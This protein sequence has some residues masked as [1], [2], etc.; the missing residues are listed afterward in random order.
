M[1]PTPVPTSAGVAVVTGGRSAE[2]DRSLLSGRTV[3][4]SLRRQGYQ[5]E[6]LDLSAPGFNE[7]VAG[8]DVAF[9]AIAGQWAEDGKLQGLLESLDVP[10][11]GS[12]VAASAVAMHKAMAKTVV[13]AAGVPVLPHVELHSGTPGS[14]PLFDGG[15]VAFPV[16]IKPLSEGGSVGMAICHT[17]QEI[18]AAIG[19]GTRGAA[20]LAEPFTPGPAITA[21][22]IERDGRPTALTPLETIPT[23]GA[24]YDYT[25]KRN[26]DRHVY[27]CP[28]AL[29]QTTVDAVRDLAIAAHQALG[30]RGYSRSDFVVDED[31]QPHWLEINTLPGLSGHGNLATMAAADN[32]TYDQLIRHILTHR[33]DPKEYRP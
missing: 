29:N 1:T 28:P 33:T 12:G 24:F 11:T 20:W 10:Y 30:C 31:G 19:Q 13:S 18:A 9:L 5:P 3:L 8:V 32:I 2:R 22:V 26:P 27:R 15:D 25:A 7:R 14:T 16:I 23:R 6:L 4:A 21:G 17:D